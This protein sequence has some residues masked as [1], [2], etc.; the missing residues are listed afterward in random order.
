MVI[1]TVLDHGQSTD[2]G[3]KKKSRIVN[4]MAS[5][6]QVKSGKG[7]KK[8]SILGWRNCNG[9]C[10][11]FTFLMSLDDLFTN[12]C[13]DVIWLLNLVLSLLFGLVFNWLFI[14]VFRLKLN[15]LIRLSLVYLYMFLCNCS[16][17]AYFKKITKM[18][19]L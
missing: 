5:L 14:L 4:K 8:K 10:L 2:K 18:C 3:I 15:L 7:W 13:L 16:M 11:I 17:H 9:Y 12:W 1:Y 6:F 19:K